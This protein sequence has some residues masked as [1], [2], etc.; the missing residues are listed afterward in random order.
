[1][2]ALK[3]F[4]ANDIDNVKLCKTIE[5]DGA[6]IV[7]QFLDSNLVSTL[8]KDLTPHL[9][10]TRLDPSGRY[11]L[12]GLLSKSPAF[13]N[14]LLHP[15]IKTFADEFLLKNCTSYILSAGVIIAVP[16]GCPDQFLHKDEIIWGSHIR[17]SVGGS[18]SVQL[19]IALDD[20]TEQNGATRIA[21]GSN[22][23]EDS[24]REP[25]DDEVCQAIMPAGS[26]LLY[27]D[28]VIHGSGAN[29]TKDKYRR[30]I[31]MNFCLGWILSVENHGLI[32][33]EHTVKQLPARAKQLLG[34]EVYYTDAGIA[35]NLSD[36]TGVAFFDEPRPNTL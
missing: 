7:H 17:K 10:S 13:L 16:P 34:Y 26:A 15:L 29:K 22:H 24:Q 19:L 31:S 35:L 14:V 28:N 36:P 1:M 12:Y 21:P 5:Q 3:S 9:E 23:W 32:I 27:V 4:E 30:A 18:I 8:N 25:T 33:P 20:F 2:V 11:K 6:V